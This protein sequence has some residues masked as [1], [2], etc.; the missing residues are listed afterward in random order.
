MP[1]IRRIAKGVS[2]FIIML[3]LLSSPAPARADDGLRW[4]LSAELMRF[5][6]REFDL[7]EHELDR[8]TGFLPGFKAHLEMEH[9]DWFGRVGAG[10]H[11]GEIDY[12]G[13]TQNGQPAETRTQTRLLDLTLNLGYW[14]V[15][16][17]PADWAGYLHFSQRQWDRDILS[18]KQAQGIYEQYSWNEVGTGVRYAWA[19]PDTSIRGHEL[20]LE[21]FRIV[22]GDI[23]VELSG[24]AGGSLPDVTL[25]LGDNSGTR[26][27][28]TLTQQLENGNR[29]RI[30]PWFA[31]WEFGRSNTAV[32]SNRD[33][34][35]RLEI[36]EPRSESWRLGVEV[37]LEF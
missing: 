31:Y 28:Y 8:E 6:Y 26:L 19:R 15:R 13:E 20:A 11:K 2:G 3:P 24:L 4:G 33:D 14:L 34:T 22:N 7:S 1:G 25:D 9:D 30:Q 21:V 32:I 35:L 12:D 5:N 27:R 10:L 16:G 23:F 18:T 17:S 29:V 36:V 37:G